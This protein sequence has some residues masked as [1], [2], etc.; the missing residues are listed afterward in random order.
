MEI[1][2]RRI[3]LSLSALSATGLLLSPCGGGPS[4][5]PAAVHTSGS[6]KRVAGQL[7]KYAALR[8]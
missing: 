6:A 7:A 4:S 5:P 8:A 2:V 1:H 3:A